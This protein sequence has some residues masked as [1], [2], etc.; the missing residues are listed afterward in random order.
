MPGMEQRRL[1]PVHPD[2][3]QSAAKLV[4]DEELADDLDE[5]DE[6]DEWDDDDIR[7]EEMPHG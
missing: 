3:K 5:E 2:T 7:P 1:L 6:E 4:I